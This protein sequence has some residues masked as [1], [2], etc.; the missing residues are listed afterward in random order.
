ML[1]PWKHSLSGQVGWG[2]EQPDLIEDDPGDCR[3]FGLDEL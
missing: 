2:A 3:G 1:H